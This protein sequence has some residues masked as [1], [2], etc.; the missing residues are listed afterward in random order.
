MPPPDAGPQAPMTAPGTWSSPPRGAIAVPATASPSPS[1]AAVFHRPAV[2]GFQARSI[3][4]ARLRSAH[5]GRVAVVASPA[6]AAPEHG[7]ALSPATAAAAHGGPRG[8]EP[9]AVA[10]I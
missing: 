6:P 2:A 1:W 9:L 10:P 7:M 8:A 5:P 3:A 4:P